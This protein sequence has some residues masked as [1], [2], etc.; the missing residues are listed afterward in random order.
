MLTSSQ[1]SKKLIKAL[2][3]SE[4]M[5]KK[6]DFII[7]IEFLESLN[8]NLMSKFFFRTACTSFKMKMQ[9]KMRTK[10]K[11]LSTKAPFD[12]LSIPKNGVD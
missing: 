9:I 10:M 12:L 2:K 5:F 6:F 3:R 8:S 4:K 1:S 11:V 7:S